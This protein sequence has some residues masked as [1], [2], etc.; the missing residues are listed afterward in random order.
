MKTQDNLKFIFFLLIFLTPIN[1]NHAKEAQPV[2]EKLDKFVKAA[3]QWR[4][5]LQAQS[6]Q[7][8]KLKPTAPIIV[9][10]A[11]SFA[12]AVISSAGGIGGGGLF[13]PILTIV[14]G[15]DLK[16]ASSFTAFMVTGVTIANV[17][18]NVL[19]KGKRNGGETLIDYEIA[20]LSEP[21]MLLGVSIGVICNIMFPDW[22]ITVMFAIFLAW[23]TFK[24]FKSGISYWKRESEGMNRDGSQKLENGMERNDITGDRREETVQSMEEPLLRKKTSPKLD[25]PWMKLGVLVL[26]W[27]SFFVIYLLHGDP[28]EQVWIL[29][30]LLSCSFLQ[31]LYYQNAVI[32]HKHVKKIAIGDNPFS[33]LSSH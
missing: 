5:E 21:C 26:I 24:T 23:S 32:T 33:G 20:L 9:A 27:I 16:R 12:A 30:Q 17:G 22:L 18:F 1:F 8:S 13:I 7:D 19:I 4:T 29:S 10:G 25:L 15:F 28:F 11:L 2:E 14:A 31:F 3:I 6:G